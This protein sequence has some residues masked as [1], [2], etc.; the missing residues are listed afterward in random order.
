MSLYGPNNYIKN[1]GNVKLLLEDREKH[2]GELEDIIAKV[3]TEKRTLTRTE[4]ERVVQLKRTVVAI[5]A[6]LKTI[7]DE[8][9]RYFNELRG[10]SG[11]NNAIMQGVI[12]P[13]EKFEKRAYAEQ[14][15]SLFRLVRGM[16]TGKWDGAQEER[17][18]YSSMSS[19]NNSVVIPQKLSDK[20]IDVMRTQAAIIGQIPVVKMPSNNLT[21]A[22]QKRDAECHFVNEGELIPAS[23]AI[24]EGVTLEGK[25][26]ACFVPISEQL[27]DSAANL[28]AQL[29]H[30]I[31]KA[32]ALELDRAVLYGRGVSRDNSHQDE[33]KGITTY[34]GI[35][36]VDMKGGFNYDHIIN[37]A[38]P[39]KKA[40]IKPTHVVYS[41][42]AGAELALLKDKN[43]NYI[44]TPK[45]MSGFTVSESNNVG[46]TEALVYN[47]DAI[48]LGLHKGITI[49]FGTT[50]DQF[51]R[52]QKGI[53]VYLRADLGIIQESG[54]T[55]LRQ[56]S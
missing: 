26:L 18:Y 39:I 52:I 25:T 44:D 9:D 20:L 15:I 24:F 34:E 14:E 41:T 17:S 43:N 30:S 50:G 48:L 55:Y 53:R 38:K 4:N 12:M 22:V 13:G 46:E 21:I 49:E 45:F 28:E 33:I 36:V 19:A 47:K 7:K 56:A 29:I 40:N 37:A 8:K 54:I 35:N 10:E 42:D 1:T 11:D 31:A 32:I 2:L 51:Q 27:I 5:D 3:E 6:E 23:E 16:C